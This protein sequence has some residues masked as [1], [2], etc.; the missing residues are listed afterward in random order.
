[1]FIACFVQY[2]TCEKENIQQYLGNRFKKKSSF[3]ALNMRPSSRD[4]YIENG[5]WY[6]KATHRI[7]RWHLLIV[8]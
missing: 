1:M 2:K 6:N 4:L 3:I 5:K 7:I 8:T